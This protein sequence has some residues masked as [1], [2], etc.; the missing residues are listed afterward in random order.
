MKNIKF[1]LFYGL[2][3]SLF[4][5]S[6]SSEDENYKSYNGSQ[7]LL[8]Y[9]QS[10]TDF[11][12]KAISPSATFIEVSSTTVSDVDRVV[13]F[14]VN[15]LL[16]TALP[17]TYSIDM[18]TAV[19]KAGSY[20]AK[21]KINSGNFNDLPVSGAAKLTLVFQPGF[22]VL[23]NRLGHVVNI[24]RNYCN[25]TKVKLFIDFDAYASE[26][27]WTVTN[28]SGGVVSSSAGYTDGKDFHSEDL[29][30]TP[31]TYT[32]NI[33]DAFGDGLSP[34]SGYTLKLTNGTVLLSGSGSYGSG[35]SSTFVVQ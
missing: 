24:S 8:F 35:K 1:S 2:F 11:E 12:Y 5:L 30:L 33:T 14:Q 25:D 27:E 32:F 6:C 26:C 10:S 19:I 18:S 3:F 16:S 28:S 20:T 31:G 17:S 4:L 21:I 9:N 7:S 13:P 23:P 34:S 29:C 22:E 15:P